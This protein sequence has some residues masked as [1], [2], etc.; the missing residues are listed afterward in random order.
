MGNKT[1]AAAQ[2]PAKVKHV[3]NA[4]LIVFIFAVFFYTMMTGMIN[5][6]RSDY[7][8][9]ILSMPLQVLPATSFH[10]STPSYLT[11]KKSKTTK[12][13]SPSALPLQSLAV[14]SPCLFS[15][16]PIFSEVTP[17]CF[18]LT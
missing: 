6:Y 11:T 4:E 2:N 12:S 16:F 17:P 18:L 1:K 3:G 9:N 5:G 13:S 14:L 10:L 8:V 15:L 7:M